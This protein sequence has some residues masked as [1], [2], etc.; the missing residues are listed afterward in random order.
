MTDCL[1]Y[2][3]DILRNH[4]NVSDMVTM[5]E[6]DATTN[7]SSTMVSPVLSRESETGS[8]SLKTRDMTL[9]LA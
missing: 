4:S 5:K 1:E 8:V 9:T 6:I 7:I 3:R 2:S